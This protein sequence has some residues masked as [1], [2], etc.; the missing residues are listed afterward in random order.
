MEPPPLGS[1]DKEWVEA[2]CML[3]QVHF[4]CA[5]LA[6]TFVLAPVV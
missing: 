4:K 6:D 5:L 1:G 3:Y 2:I